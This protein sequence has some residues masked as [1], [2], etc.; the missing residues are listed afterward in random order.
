MW[1]RIVREFSLFKLDREKLTGR[2][3]VY[4]N[5]VYQGRRDCSSGNQTFEEI[6]ENGTKAIV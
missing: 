4:I 3:V 5:S 6:D 2:I 1:E